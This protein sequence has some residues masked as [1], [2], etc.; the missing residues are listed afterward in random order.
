MGAPGC[1]LKVGRIQLRKA[2][3]TYLQRVGQLL[4]R[5][6]IGDLKIQRWTVRTLGT[7]SVLAERSRL[8]FLPIASRGRK[9]TIAKS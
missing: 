4:V 7:E 6:V 3:G 9:L 2:V 5:R 8:V 1:H